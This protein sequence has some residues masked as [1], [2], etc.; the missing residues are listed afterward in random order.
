MTT[1]DSNP[2]A[3]ISLATITYD[4]E[5]GTLAQQKG[6]NEP[7]DLAVCLPRQRPCVACGDLPPMTASLHSSR[8]TPTR[9]GTQWPSGAA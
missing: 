7:D 5:G 8:S 1:T 4:D 9:L 3:A 2:Y 6:R